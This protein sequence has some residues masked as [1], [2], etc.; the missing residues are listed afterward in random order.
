M[1]LGK[2]CFD[3]KLKYITLPVCCFLLSSCNVLDPEEPIPSFIQFSEPRLNTNFQ[4]EGSNSH[5]I[6]D[7][8]V[9]V[10]D[11]FLG[12]YEYPIEIPVLQEG[13]KT[14]KVFPGI[15]D[16]GL[17]A[18]RRIYP[19]YKAYENDST[20]NLEA[21]KSLSFDPVFSYEDN[22]EFVWME[23]FQT[24]N[25]GITNDPTSLSQFQT[26][27]GPEA[28]ESGTSGKIVLNIEDFRG[29][30]LQAN[31][32]QLPGFGTEIYLELDFKNDIDFVVGLRS[33]FRDGSARNLDLVGIN[34]SA[35][36]NKIYIDLREFVSR[37]MNATAF[38]IYFFANYQGTKEE[39]LIFLDNIKLIHF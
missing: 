26:T 31:P 16:N 30:F 33:Y 12:V 11:E 32:L 19:F 10:G 9:Y 7:Y 34:P 13:S 20:A 28:F 37:E 18:Q 17:S 22:V 1:C 25:L 5:N 2:P 29:F 21:G 4:Q 39:E 35:E 36:W 38:Q 6:T 24:L 23:A 14:V 27:S 15:K 3:L 8:W